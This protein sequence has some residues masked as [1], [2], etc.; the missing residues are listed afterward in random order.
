MQER[1]LFL[2]SYVLYQQGYI[3]ENNQPNPDPLF[4]SALPSSRHPMKTHLLLRFNEV[5]L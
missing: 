4:Y 1:F 5:S 2:C 3:V